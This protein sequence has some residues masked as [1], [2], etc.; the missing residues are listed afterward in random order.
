MFLNW[1]A[2]FI[3]VKYQGVEIPFFVI[4]LL[5]IG[6]L[7]NIIS[8]NDRDCRFFSP[9]GGEERTIKLMENQV[10]TS[11]SMPLLELAYEDGVVRHPF[12]L[13]CCMN[14]WYLGSDFYQAVKIGIVQYVSTSLFASNFSDDTFQTFWSNFFLQMILKTICALLAIILQIF[15]VYGE[16]KFEWTCG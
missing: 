7:C 2:L 13:N 14:N 1:F 3:N 15:G 12:P 6:S 5:W 10:R 9:L 11:S 4:C 16:G 8:I